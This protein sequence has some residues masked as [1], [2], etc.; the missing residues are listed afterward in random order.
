MATFVAK[1]PVN[2]A[3]LPGPSILIRPTGVEF[4]ER[5]PDGFT[6]E[7]DDGARLEVGGRDFSYFFGQPRPMGTVTEL[8]YFAPEGLTFNLTDA[9]VSLRD[10][11]ETDVAGAMPLL[12]S[13]DD[14]LKGSSLNDVLIG[15][16]GNDSVF[17]RGGNDILQG[18]KG[19]DAIDG[20]KGT[21]QLD[22]GGGK[23]SYLFKADPISG[24]D[25][26]LNF[27]NGETLKIGLAVFDA[28][29]AG[30]LERICFQTRA[31]MPRTKMTVLC[32]NSKRAIFSMIR[33]ALAISNASFLG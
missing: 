5:G 2:M 7:R 21:D 24:V 11:I 19:K 17:G 32:T 18:K 13:D 27:R 20:G 6:A 29:Q 9:D 15:Y 14:K 31:R 8:K 1:L 25:T 12:F 4:S 16:D 28:L 30:P 33:T 3:S 22:G 10:L 23:D 26:I